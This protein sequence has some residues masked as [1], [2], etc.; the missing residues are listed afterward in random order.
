MAI[1]TAM[2]RRR[3]S[4][5]SAKAPAGKSEQEERQADADL[6]QGY[7]DRIGAE[8]CDEPAGRGVEHGSAD[9]RHDARGPN[10]RERNIAERAPSRGRGLRRGREESWFALKPASMAL[11]RPRRLAA[12]RTRGISNNIA[13]KF[14]RSHSIT[15]RQGGARHFSPK[16]PLHRWAGRIRQSRETAIRRGARW[17]LRTRL[18]SIFYAADRTATFEEAPGV[19]RRGETT[20]KFFRARS[21]A[22]FDN[23]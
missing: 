21:I 20:A 3:K 5:T 23:R 22:A 2:S 10:D 12:G 11:R 14:R 4:M 16:R 15:I 19:T 6:N 1:S 7:G 18:T 8:T 9:V 17:Q 13:N